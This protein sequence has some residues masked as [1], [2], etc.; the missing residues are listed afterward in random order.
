M[1]H[2]RILIRSTLLL[3]L[4]GIAA[5]GQAQ[6]SVRRDSTADVMVKEVLLGKGIL[7][8][9]VR[10]TGLPDAIG[11]F[12]FP[13]SAGFFQSGVVL[14]TGKASD[15]AGPNIHPKTSTYNSVPGDK[16]LSSVAGGRTFD[17][18]VLEFDFMADKDSVAFNFVFASEEYND[19]V[20]STYNDAFALVISGPNMPAKNFAVLPGT[21]SPISV[22]SVNANSNRKYYWDNNPFTLVGK[23]NE[24]VKASLNQDILNNVGF[25]GMTKV[26]SVGCRVVPKQVYHFQMAIADAGDGTVD[27]AVLLEGESFKSHEQYKHVLRRIQLAE[28][29]RLDSLARVKAVE[30]SLRVVAELNMLREKV[31]RDSIERVRLEQAK[32]GSD[33]A[34][35]LGLASNDDA[36]D[37]N[38]SVGSDNDATVDDEGDDAADEEEDDEDEGDD[39]EED[40]DE[41]EDLDEVGWKATSPTDKAPD[42]P[43][44]KPEDETP[45]VKKP[46]SELQEVLVYAG[47]SYLLDNLAEDRVRGFGKM[48][49][50]NPRLKL[51]IY[52]A[53][54][55]PT[56][57]IN[58]RFDLI[59]LELIKAGAKPDQI[60]R[61]GFS[62][63][64][65][66]E[67]HR[68]EVWI[69]EE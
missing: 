39:E 58:M 45:A 29:R 49:A 51:G 21:N 36:G 40:G 43:A 55:D 44:T 13:N 32:L 69:R 20:G 24:A 47:D 67:S 41:I 63:G 17:A 26:M 53:G 54:G 62:F 57:V 22:N 33:P 38:R 10:F 9:G 3:T 34:N 68:A 37:T 19:Y 8:K 50:G 2:L 56:E 4:V 35:E 27:S 65:S 30:D 25:D 16:N 64:K 48:L 46:T 28:E 6:L 15:L 66:N 7:V 23:V 11:V 18:A 1:R 14:S 5:L 42:N 12:S 59:R 52:L 60:F 61:N 31:R